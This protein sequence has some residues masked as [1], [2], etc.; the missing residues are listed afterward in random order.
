MKKAICV[1]FLALTAV[2]GGYASSTSKSKATI[3]DVYTFKMAVKTP[4]VYD[5]MQSKGYRKYRID[6]LYGE[7]HLTYPADGTGGAEI[8]VKNLKNRSY[9]VGGNYVTYETYLDE[10][11]VC[12][13]V[14]LI[15]SN[16]TGIFKKPSVAFALVCDPSYNVGEMDEDNTL[17]ITLSGSGTVRKCKNTREQLIKSM[18]GY[19]SG[20]LGCGC[21]AYGHMS[22]TRVN[23]AYGPICDMVDDVAAVW[24]TWKAIYRHSTCD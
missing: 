16:K 3:T 4:R 6:K 5:N 21:S 17:Y 12:P 8:S 14:N 23:G 19:L 9:K 20:T 13:R 15:G 11:K 2:V 24:G 22:P 1:L 10:D 7:L 18:S